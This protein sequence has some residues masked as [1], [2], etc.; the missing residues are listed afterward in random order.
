MAESSNLSFLHV[1]KSLRSLALSLVLGLPLLAQ[2]PAPPAPGLSL[3]EAIHRVLARYPS[4]DAAQNAIEAARGQVMQAN[5]SRLPQVTA[6]GAYQYTSLR[7]YIDFALPGSPPSAFYTSIQNSYNATVTARQLLTDFGRTEALVA[8]ARS[9]AI[10]AQDALEQVK[11]QLGYETIQAFYGVILLRAS[12]DVA[13]EEIRALEEA[14]RI[15]ERKFNGGTATKFDLLTTQVRLANARNRR[16]D[17]ESALAK[18]ESLLRR[19]LGQPAGEPVT[20][21]GAFDTSTALPDLSTTLAEGLQNRPEMKLAHDSEHTA[22]LSLTAADRENRP[23][24]AAQATG[25]LQDG[26]LPGLYNNRGYVAAGVSVSVPLFTG[27]RITGERITA[28]ADYRS[29]QDRVSELDRRITSDIEDAF[30]DLKAAQA[31]LAN[32]DLLVAQAQEALSLAKSRYTNGVITNFELLDAQSNAR[33]AEQTRLQARYDWVLA[34]QEIA[35][36]AGRA[37]SATP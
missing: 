36:A 1:M 37:P 19:L 30:S 24:L 25:G 20:V 32:A 35:Q 13:A 21:I 27:R 12:D 29:A 7:P 10:S 18:Q 5:A 33:A 22:E 23:V 28:R 8:M 26:D 9:G 6:D 3:E 16:T 14:L 2:E 15:S 34:G 4:L 17:T 11:N 31:K